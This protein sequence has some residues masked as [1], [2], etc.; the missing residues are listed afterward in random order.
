MGS[1]FCTHMHGPVL[2]RNPRLADHMLTLMAASHGATYTRGERGADVDEIAKAARNSIA[3][4][5]SLA[6]E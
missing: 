6:S 2:A 1:V 5:L 3:V 4:R